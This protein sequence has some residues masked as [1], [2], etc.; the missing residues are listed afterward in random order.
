LSTVTPYFGDGVQVALAMT[1]ALLMVVSIKAYTKRPE[2]RYLLLMLAFV[3]FCIASVSNTVLALYAGS[4]PSLVP[5]FELYLIP[6]LELLTVVSL[7]IAL[8]WSSRIGRRSLTLFLAVVLV[9][10][11]LASTAYIAGSG[12]A[13]ESILPTGCVKP[14]GGFLIIAS[15]LGYN[16]SIAHGAPVKSWPVL[17]VTKGTD[18]SI[19]LCNTYS[20]AVGFQVEHY[21]EGNTETVMPGQV[22]VASF[23]ANETGSFSIYCAIFNPIHIYLQG[24]ELNVL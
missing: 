9:V 21:L 7:L 19:T 8:V 2:G 5:L 11:L 13:G 24:G 10:G 14:A 17:D 18:V 12:G 6:S 20:Q 15:S 4:G 16:D 22:F 1:S 23:L 3:F